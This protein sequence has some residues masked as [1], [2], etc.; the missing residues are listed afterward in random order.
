M[1]CG[2]VCV[3]KV[4]VRAYVWV[5]VCR[6]KVV[7]KVR[8]EWVV[9]WCVV[10]AVGGVGVRVCVCVGVRVCGVCVCVCLSLCV[11]EVGGCWCVLCVIVVC[12]VSRSK[13]NVCTF[14]APPCVPEIGPHAQ[15]MWAWCQYTQ[16]RFERTHAGV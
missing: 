12:R 8:V 13:L 11:G 4:R 15:N 5:K 7:L 9:S 1:L 10:F 3:L 16:R 6:E 14:I 2:C